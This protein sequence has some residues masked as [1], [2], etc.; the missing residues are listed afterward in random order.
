M[1]KEGT[2]TQSPD[3]NKERASEKLFVSVSKLVPDIDAAD[4]THDEESTFE[5]ST[6]ASFRNNTDI[7][8]DY[9][10]GFVRWLAIDAESAES[11]NEALRGQVVVDIG[12]GRY[13]FGYLIADRAGAKGYVGVDAYSASSLAA[14]TQSL[15]TDPKSRDQE[16]FGSVQPPLITEVSIVEEDM[17]TFLKRLPDNSVS[18]FCSGIDSDIINY[19][20]EKQVSEEIK[21]V[22]KDDGA[23]VGE[24]F[25][26][27]VFL[28]D[29][30]GEF[31]VERPSD[32][33]VIYR[34][35][36]HDE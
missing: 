31:D 2:P 21:R 18:V 34:R 10:A 5:R 15:F 23:Y 4:L 8:T 33:V 35:K 7:G 13:P 26:G 6:R 29:Q 1:A 27:H 28:H 9:P 30:Q 12:A 36:K 32:K 3:T 25:G 20:Y 11:L 16:V 24:K 17:L 14:T 22:L 19:E